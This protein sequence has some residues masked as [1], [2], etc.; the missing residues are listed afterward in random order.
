MKRNAQPSYY[1]FKCKY[2][3]P[4]ATDVISL[5]HRG[6]SQSN[7]YVQ[8]SGINEQLMNKARELQARERS[9]KAGS[10]ASSAKNSLSFRRMET[11]I[12]LYNVTESKINY[13]SVEGVPSESDTKLVQVAMDDEILLAYAKNN[14]PN[15]AGIG[16]I[17][18]FAGP[19]IIT[20]DAVCGSWIYKE[21]RQAKSE[22]PV[23]NW[24]I[25][26][27]DGKMDWFRPNK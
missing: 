11:Q 7:I 4:G 18:A 13:D 6:D 10:G 20:P 21:Q 26:S 3:I 27:S 2:N 25:S 1:R 9:E 16:S 17:C 22:K 5:K 15:K 12:A 8:V 23:L 24:I 14:H 19:M